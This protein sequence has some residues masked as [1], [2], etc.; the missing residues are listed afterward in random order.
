MSMRA[1]ES[2]LHLHSSFGVPK[3][4]KNKATVLPLNYARML[5]ARLVVGEGANFACESSKLA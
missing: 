1:Q 4:G 3:R 5:P 2:D